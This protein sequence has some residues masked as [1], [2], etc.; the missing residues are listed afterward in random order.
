M[1][2]CSYPPPPHPR[3][4]RNV[5]E[6]KI[7]PESKGKNGGK[8]KKGNTGKGE[9]QGKLRGRRGKASREGKWNLEKF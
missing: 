6:D 1:G 7:I 8:A 2:V 3:V 5:R 4:R 9:K